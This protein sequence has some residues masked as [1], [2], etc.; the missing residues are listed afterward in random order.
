MGTAQQDL[1]MFD[2]RVDL[3][4]C[5]NQG[6]GI[7]PSEAECYFGDIRKWFSTLEAAQE[8]LN[9]FED[10]EQTSLEITKFDRDE[11]IP[12]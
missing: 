10:F 8:Y 11:E 2:Y 3:K 5:E 7:Y 9:S 4:S 6:N 1:P 12:F